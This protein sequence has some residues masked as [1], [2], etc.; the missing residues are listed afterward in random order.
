MVR[1]PRRP[2][3][4]PLM[5]SEEPDAVVVDFDEVVDAAPAELAVGSNVLDL[6]GMDRQ[7]A[8]DIKPGPEKPARLVIR[9]DDRLGLRRR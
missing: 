9:T 4:E 8:A 1:A 3:R 2:T 5:S 7:L 6:A